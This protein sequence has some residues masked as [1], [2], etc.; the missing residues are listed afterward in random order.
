MKKNRRI[1]AC[2]AAAA[3]VFSSHAV[4]LAADEATPEAAAE[5]SKPTAA[6]DLGVFS[7]Y[8]WRGFELS[9]NSI[10]I[11]PSA[12]LGYEGFSV[13]MW[14][15]MDTDLHTRDSDAS[16]SKY[17]ETDMTLSYAKT[18]GPVKLTGGYIY[19][20]LDGTDDTQE[21]FV[22]ATLNTI[23]NPTLSVYRDIASAPAWY[24]NFGIS[25]SQPIVDKITLDLAASAGYYYSDDD[26]FTE[27]DDP[28]SKYREFHNGLVTAGL[29]IP[30]GEYF[31]VK[32]LIGYSFPLS[33]QAD[34]YITA[35]SISDNSSFVYG[36]ITLSMA[37]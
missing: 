28:E 9:H 19:Y 17:T 34:D 16:T 13:N 1:L 2:I 33:G 21:L 32:P 10:V 22:S 5:A 18:L 35:T 15:N 31:S 3:I 25:H 24:I 23:L 36:G 30:F 7:Q 14:G 20:A 11:Q 4:A 37:F 29:T 6:L 27:V 8:I 12:T 26:D